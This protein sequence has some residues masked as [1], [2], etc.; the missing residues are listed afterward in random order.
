MQ[1]VTQIET[2]NAFRQFARYVVQ[3]RYNETSKPIDKLYGLL[4]LVP[5]TVGLLF[6][7]RYDEDIVS[8][9]QR[10]ATQI[11]RLSQSLY[12]LSQVHDIQFY[13]ARFAAKLPSWVP[14]WSAMPYI[15]YKWSQSRF[16]AEREDIF[17][18]LSNAPYVI[19]TLDNNRILE[20]QGLLVNTV[21]DCLSDE[22]YETQKWRELIGYGR[23]TLSE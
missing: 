18:A 10:T 13:T 17:D 19:Q 7:P 8:M 2:R 6:N 5:D 4:G 21:R 23:N 12:I 15:D 9:Y 22:I 3:F 16:R 11:I 14:D 20:L 1:S